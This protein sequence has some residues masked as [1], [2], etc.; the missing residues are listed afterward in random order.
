MSD[1]GRLDGVV[2]DFD[3]I[4]RKY[5]ARLEDAAVESGQ[6]PGTFAGRTLLAKDGGLNAGPENVEMTA[7]LAEFGDFDDREAGTQT[8]TGAELPAIEPGGGEVLA[9]EPRGH[10]PA[11]G[12]DL[13]EGLLG[14]QQKSLVRPAVVPTVSLD[15]ARQALRGNFALEE[16]VLRHATRGGAELNDSAAHAL[17]LASS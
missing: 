10:G 2:N 9:H 1:S 6:P 5:G 11:E 16:R 12:L 14:D 17:I 8:L 15:V 3:Y 7:G 4:A 13:S